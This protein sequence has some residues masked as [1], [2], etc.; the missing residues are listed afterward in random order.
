LNSFKEDN[1][2]E[3]DLQ[4][5]ENLIDEKTVTIIVNNPSNPCGSVFS[6]AHLLNIIK[7]AEKY[8]LPIIG[9]EVYGDMVIFSN[10]LV[11]FEI[12]R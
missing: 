2:W 12:D 9:D 7:L 4:Q 6:K 10:Q 11:R 8:K 1:N 3:A 5:L